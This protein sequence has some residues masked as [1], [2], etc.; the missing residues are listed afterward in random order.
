MSANIL[1]VYDTTRLIS[2]LT[3][4]CDGLTNVYW[5]LGNP[6]TNRLQIAELYC[7]EILNTTDENIVMAYLLALDEIVRGLAVS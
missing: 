5:H 7:Y 4:T 3:D 1:T 6:K 2:W